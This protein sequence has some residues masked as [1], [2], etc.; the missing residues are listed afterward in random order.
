VT[1]VAVGDIMLA[2]S[3][4][5][6]ILSAGAGIVFDDGI[7][8]L[9]ADTVLVDPA[10][11]WTNGAVKGFTTVPA[12]NQYLYLVN[13]EAGTVGTYTAGKFLIELFGYRA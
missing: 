9:T 4:G 3:V 1:I 6:R 5:Q 12:A 11:A 13:G 2:R 7:A 8:A 10:A